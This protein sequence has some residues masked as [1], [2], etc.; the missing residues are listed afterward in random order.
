MS[1]ITLAQQGLAA[2]EARDWPTAITKLTTAIQ[3]SQNPA[4]LIA[5]SRA[6]IGNS[7]FREALADA[8]LAWHAALARNNFQAMVDAQ[9]RRA[10]AHH[11]LGE[12]ANAD[13]CCIYAIRLLTGSTPHGLEKADPKLALLGED[14]FWR[15]TLE[16]AK[17]EADEGNN[18]SS[19]KNASMKGLL[20]EGPSEKTKQWRVVSVLR[21]QALIKMEKLPVDDAA[22]KVTV[23]LSPEH[24]ELAP[25]IPQPT[26]KAAAKTENPADIPV[27]FDD[28]Q[29]D[30]TM[31]VTIFSKGVDKSKLQ[32]DFLPKS[33]RL[34]AV[35]NPNGIEREFS[36]DLYG[37]ID[38]SASKYNVT[39]S[40]VEVVLMKKT[41]GKWPRLKAVAPE[42]ININPPITFLDKGKGKAIPETTETAKPSVSAK[43]S[44]PARPS[45][46]EKSSAPA[47][48]SS[49]RTGPK[50]WDNL[51][52]DAEDD[53]S[54]VNGFFKMLYKDATPEARRAMMKSFTESGGTSLSTSWEDVKDKT[55]HPVPPEGVEAKKW[56]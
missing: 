46:A 35:I 34:D 50:N 40:K 1:H 55:V 33:V 11:R 54:D 52:V 51:E 36:L 27:R 7:S 24:R 13:C 37:E 25:V 47:Y 31:T 5:R 2:V 12:Y 23:N 29:T 18:T 14:G 10:V 4:W 56:D 39:P 42:Q 48:P 41:P 28:F 26:L 32:V 22:R 49:S 16:D 21:Q 6:L 30:T 3:S 43:S 38:P 15:G 19:S 20:P 17:R 45:F 8:E 53:S 9:Y 44:V